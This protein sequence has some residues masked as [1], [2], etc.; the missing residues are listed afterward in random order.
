MINQFIVL[1]NNVWSNETSYEKDLTVASSSLGQCEVTSL[2][3]QDYFGGEIYKIKVGDI[4]H[5]FN[6]VH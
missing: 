2:L 4:Y 5:Y 3:F 1:I 6:E